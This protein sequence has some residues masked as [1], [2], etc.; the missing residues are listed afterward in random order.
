MVTGHLRDK[1]GIY[2]IILN[3]KDAKGK[4]RTKSVSTG[5]PVRGNKKRA[6]DMLQAERKKFEQGPAND[7]KDVLFSDY[8]LSWLDMM[9]NSIEITTYGSYF[10]IVK[11]HIVP[12]F[13]EKKLLLRDVKPK[14]IQD[15]Y[16][17]ELN[18]KGVSA[19]TVIHYHANIRKA[20]RYAFVTGDDP[21]QSG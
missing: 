1:N 17:Y 7:N 13:K 8:L 16:Q 21:I 15:F 19:N 12:Y 5:F 10:Y 2:Q 20:L 3:Y 18:D 6:E 14:H 4:Y 11:N 9:K